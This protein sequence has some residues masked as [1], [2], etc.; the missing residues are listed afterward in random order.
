MNT[1]FRKDSIE[2]LPKSDVW[3]SLK[4]VPLI[5]EIQLKKIVKK[6]ETLKD[7]ISEQILMATNRSY[8]PMK[9]KWLTENDGN[10]KRVAFPVKMKKWWREIPNGKFQ[11][12]IYM[13]GKPLEL[14]TGK[15]AI[16]V[17]NF[18]HIV[19]TLQKIQEAVDLGD[20]DELIQSVK[21]N[22]YFSD[23]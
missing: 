11:L 23:I 8:C 20:F 2:S 13:R 10:V 9:Y 14:E 22:G 21:I 16:E 4:L 1:H 15:H 19:P 3:A 6:R 5:P 12:C 17:K 18:S 7:Q